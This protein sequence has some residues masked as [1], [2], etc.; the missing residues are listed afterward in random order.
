MKIEK[1]F[2]QALVESEARM[3]FMKLAAEKDEANPS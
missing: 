1:N 3:E 2:N